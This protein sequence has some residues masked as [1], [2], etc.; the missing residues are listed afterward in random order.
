MRWSTKM[1]T[2]ALVGVLAAAAGCRKT[3]VA[4]QPMNH[5]S[6]AAVAPSA[7]GQA[8]AARRGQ[9]PLQS[10]PGGPAAPAKV[11]TRPAPAATEAAE[12]APSTASLPVYLPPEPGPPQREPLWKQRA[13]TY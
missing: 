10:D 11:A 8:A 3:V 9:E 13:K 4:P 2:V 7:G 12:A 1:G 5:R 6:A